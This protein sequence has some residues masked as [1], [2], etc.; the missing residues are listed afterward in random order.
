VSLVQFFMDKHSMLLEELGQDMI[1]TRIS[2][3]MENIPD[4]Q[5]SDDKTV[6]V[7]INASVATKEQPEEYYIEPDWGLLKKKYDE[8]WK[9]EAYPDMYPPDEK[10]TVT[11]DAVEIPEETFLEDIDFLPK[12]RKRPDSQNNKVKI[13]AA[14]LII[15]VVLAA[16]AGLFYLLYS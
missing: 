13:I 5:V 6:V 16:M 3:F 4:E 9:R 14:V 1:Q 12:K 10:K 7:V 8:E 15:L 2:N 11:E